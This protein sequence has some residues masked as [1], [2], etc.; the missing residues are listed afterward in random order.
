VNGL[1]PVK[2]QNAVACV[3]STFFN[4]L[5]NFC[6]F[7]GNLSGLLVKGANDTVEHTHAHTHTHTHTHSVSY[8]VY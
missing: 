7:Y 8:H 2:I 6:K 4:S 1:L 5:V 3:N